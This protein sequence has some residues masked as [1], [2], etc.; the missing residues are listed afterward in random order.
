[1]QLRLDNAGLKQKLQ[2]LEWSKKS[3]EA[4]IEVHEMKLAQNCNEI[5]ALLKEN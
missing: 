4:K 3:L 2:D 5:I 1:M